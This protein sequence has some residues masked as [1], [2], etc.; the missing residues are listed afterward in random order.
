MKYQ[1]NPQS[2]PHSAAA[3]QRNESKPDILHKRFATRKA[4]AC[5]IYFS[6]GQIQWDTRVE[7]TEII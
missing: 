5:Y 1:L 6:L 3:P 4:I 2:H 7:S